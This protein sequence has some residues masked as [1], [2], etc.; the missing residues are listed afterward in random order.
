[1]T[2]GNDRPQA[3]GPGVRVDTQRAADSITAQNRPPLRQGD[4]RHAPSAVLATSYEVVGTRGLRRAVLIV[5][6]PFCGCCHQHSAA[7][8]FDAG[9]R[10]ASCHQGRYVV[11][12]SVLE[13]RAA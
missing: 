10:T 9:R 7:A 12:A 2:P 4:L 5:E 8:P 3:G 13:G 1:M 11:F 6:C